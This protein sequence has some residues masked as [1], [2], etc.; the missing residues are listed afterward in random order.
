M[1]PEYE[2]NLKPDKIKDVEIFLGMSFPLSLPYIYRTYRLVMTQSV[3]LYY[4]PL[5]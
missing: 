3:L 2:A 4:L 1:M 5:K